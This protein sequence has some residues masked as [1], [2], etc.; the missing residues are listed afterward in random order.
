MAMDNTLKIALIS[1]F[2]GGAFAIV[3]AF[4]NRFFSIRS[5]RPAAAAALIKKIELAIPYDNDKA[6]KKIPVLTLEDIAAFKAHLWCWQVHKLNP[7]WLEYEKYQYTYLQNR[8]QALQNLQGF[9][10]K[11]T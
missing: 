3:V 4:L 6:L 1:V 5:A 9:A 2:G 10:K 7:L 8:V 11:C